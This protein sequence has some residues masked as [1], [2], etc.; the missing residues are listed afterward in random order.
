MLALLRLYPY[1]IIGVTMTKSKLQE[2]IEDYKA[3]TVYASIAAFMLGAGSLVFW[4]LSRQSLLN[5]TSPDDMVAFYEYSVGYVASFL[6]GLIA[7]SFLLIAA[8]HLFKW[9]KYR[10]H[11]EQEEEKSL[12]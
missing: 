5:R 8:Y 6:F 4:W 3:G 2:A 1:P 7:I 12:Q 10:R 9:L 11:M